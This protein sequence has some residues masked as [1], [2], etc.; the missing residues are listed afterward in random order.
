MAIQELNIN[1]ALVETSVKGPKINVGYYESHTA[2]THPAA[3]LF[4]EHHLSDSSMRPVKQ[5]S[6][7]VVHQVGSGSLDLGIIPARDYMARELEQAENRICI[8]AA[9]CLGSQYDNAILWLIGRDGRT[10]PTGEDLTTIFVNVNKPKN[11][12]DKRVLDRGMLQIVL[13]E[14]R[15]TVH[16]SPQ[17]TMWATLNGHDSDQPIQDTLTML[18]CIFNGGLRV[19][20]S[21]RQIENLRKEENSMERKPD[22]PTPPPPGLLAL[23]KPDRTLL[24]RIRQEYGKRPAL[25]QH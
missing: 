13:S 16:V 24:D 12:P 10:Q 6:L 22:R 17:G 5:N 1:G 2:Y 4:M 20:G 11:N 19:M 7:E 14:R 9:A 18:R 23:P 25:G 15:H 3:K 21:Y 8:L